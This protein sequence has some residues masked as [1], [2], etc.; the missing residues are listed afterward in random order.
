MELN[1]IELALKEVYD[2]W[3]FGSEKENNGYSAMFRM[4]FP[5]EYIDSERPLLMYVGQEDLNGDEYKTQEWVRKYQLVQL[6]ENNDILPNEKVNGSPF[7]KLC[8]DLR[9]MGYNCLWNNLDKLLKADHKTHISAEE[10]AGFNAAYGVDRKSVLQREI[11]LLKP[12]AIIFAIGPRWKYIKSLASSFSI[13][14]SLLYPYKPTRKS[15]VND[16]SSVLCLQ[17]T[18][19]LWMYHPNYLSRGGL[20]D[21]ALQKIE[22]LL[23]Y[24]NKSKKT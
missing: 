2:C 11:E 19:V 13:D 6:K 10:A 23:K 8:R 7:W 17:D 3:Q 22:M 14:V 9:D 12:N 15:C 1:K 20:K 4:G 21:E 5:D 18:V 24:K 16:I